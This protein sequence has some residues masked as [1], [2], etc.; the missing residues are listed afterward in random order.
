MFYQLFFSPQVKRCAIITYKYSI[1][2]LLHEL[3]TDV[4]LRIK[5]LISL[6]FG[7]NSL[8][9][10]IYGLNPPIKMQFEEY[11]GAKNS[12][13]FPSGPSSTHC[14]WN[15]HRS[16]LIPRSFPRSEKFLAAR[17]NTEFYTCLRNN[18]NDPA[19]AFASDV[20][21]AASALNHYLKVARVGTERIAVSPSTSHLNS[22]GY[23][24]LE[25]FGELRI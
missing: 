24:W 20:I 23:S 12:K 9:A 10:P 3:P 17:W 2:E 11:L 14:R 21:I 19:Q 18:S 5:K 7:K 1:Y 25:I 15:A 13:S 22:L 8:I 6:I 16:A 4:R